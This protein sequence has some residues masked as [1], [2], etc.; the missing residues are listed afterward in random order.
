[1]TACNCKTNCGHACGRCAQGEG[2]RRR[3]EKLSLL[4]QRRA[5]FIRHGQRVLL[6]TATNAGRASADDVHAAMELPADLDARFLGC[7]PVALAHA[8]LVRSAGFIKSIRPQ[9][10]ASYIQ[11]WALADREAAVRWLAENPDLPDPAPNDGDTAPSLFPLPAAQI[12]SPAAATV[13]RYG[14]NF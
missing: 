6:T 8:G 1:M 4:A 13:G 5:R 2:A 9:R 11:L 12:K 14:R 10:H 3:D 7:V